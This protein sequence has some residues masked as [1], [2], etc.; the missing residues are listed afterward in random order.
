MTLLLPLSLALTVVSVVLLLVLVRRSATG[1]IERAVRD[2]LRQSRDDSAKLARELRDE[3]GQGLKSSTDALVN[4]VTSLGTLQHGQLETFGGQLSAL[5]ESTQGRL[6]GIRSVVESQLTEMRTANNLK[7]NEVRTTLEESLRAS[8]EDGSK[9]TQ[10]L[11]DE[12]AGRLT[13][14]QESTEKRYDSMRQTV[15]TKLQATQEQTAA[16]SQESS[17][18]AHTLRDEVTNRL[19]T[20]QESTETRYDAMRH[21]VDEKLQATQEHAVAA[22]EASS[23]AAESLRDAVTTRLTTFQESTEN[24]F[25]AMRRTVDEKLQATQDQTAKTSGEL[26]GEIRATLKGN[27]DSVGLQLKGLGDTTQ[28]RLDAVKGTVDVQLKAIQDGNAKGLDAIRKTVDEQLQTTLEKRLTESFKLVSGQLESVQRGLGEMQT[29]ATGVGDL[30]RV[31]TNVK[32]RG[33]WAEYQLGAI[34]E[35]IL[36]PDQYSTNV[37]I[38]EH[39]GERVEFA[40]RLPGLTGDPALS[41]WL[42]IDSKF[43]QESYLRLMDA[44]D[45]ADAAAMQL[46]YIE[47]ARAIRLQAEAIHDKYVSP[48][49]TTDFAILFLPTEGLYAEVLRQPSL[50][51][52][53]QHKFRV[54]VAGPTSLAALLSSIRVG[55]QTVAINRHANEIWTVLRAV[56]TE[57]GKFGGVLGKLHKQLDR[58]TRTIDD[59]TVRTRAME[60]QLRDVEELPAGL[61]GQVLLLPEPVR[62][63]EIEPELEIDPDLLDKLEPEAV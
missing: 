45:A 20:F 28:A 11:R 59:T 46:A 2:E 4:A 19:T 37:S 33:T 23:K 44:A 47:L 60:R 27:A 35:E 50:A 25:D 62:D 36:T 63:L 3:L 9:A 16:A 43:P 51:A 12:L 34:L 13:T 24:R 15:D 6:D 58:A 56:K 30:K 22:S 29:L 38:H 53:L 52:E 54:M 48:P 57:F 49:T 41:V 61:A 42:P 18:A 8:A 21:T 7:F 10:A 17:K 55:F 31:L 26:R 39:S 40:V 32:A 14:F 1:P 5:T